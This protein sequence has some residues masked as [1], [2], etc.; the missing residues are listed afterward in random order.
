MYVIDCYGGI[1]VAIGE[2]G[3][4]GDLEGPD[5]VYGFGVLEHFGGD[6]CDVF[7]LWVC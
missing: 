1:W 3:E 5:A 7:G 6:G 2:F 4:V